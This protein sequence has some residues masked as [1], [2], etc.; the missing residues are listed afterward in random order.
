M[1]LIAIFFLTTA[2]PDV[3]SKEAGV[4]TGIRSINEWRGIKTTDAPVFQPRIF[5][6]GDLFYLEAWG[7]MDLDDKNDSQFSFTEKTFYRRPGI[8]LE[9][10]H[11]FHRNHAVP[12]HQ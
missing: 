10:R 11:V 5:F 2:T 12:V 7:S 3:F 8:H 6:S 9:Q 4:E 1:C